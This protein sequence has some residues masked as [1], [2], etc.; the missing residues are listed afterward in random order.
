MKKI[1]LLI[2]IIFGLLSVVR[3][4]VG[5]NSLCENSLPFCTG[6][7]Y[8][9]PA[10]V[11][12]G[13]AQPGPCYSCLTTRPNPAWYFM[14]IGNPGNI[15]IYMYSTPLVDIDFCLWGP[16]TS[17]NACNE[18]T[19]NKVVDCSY[20]PN[21]QEWADIPN[22]LTGQYY[23]LL[24]TNYSNQ[25][26]NINFSQTAGTG[27]TDCSIL[28][29]PCSSNSPLCVGQTL[30][31]TASS[32][33]GA[34]YHWEGP[35][36]WTS[37][38]Q[39]PTILNVNMSHNGLYSLYV[40]ANGQVLDPTTTL[41]HVYN[42]TANAG[43]DQSIPYGANTTLN[44]S[45][46]QGS[47]HY[48]YHW[49]PA[50]LLVNPNIAK[51]TTVNLTATQMFTLTVVDDSAS[52]TDTDVMTVD[53]T[54]GPLGASAAAQP[55]EICPGAT[56]Q[57]HALPSGGAGNYTFQWTGPDGFSSTLQ[58]PMVQPAQTGQ[59]HVAVT[60]GF[61]TANASV[62]V[63][64]HP[65]PLA[66]A[67]TNTGIPHGTYTFLHGN[68]TQGSGNYHYHWTPADKVANPNVKD[69][70][71]V[72]LTQTTVYSLTVDDVTTGCVSNNLANVTVEITGGPLNVNPVATPPM[73][74][75]GETV[76]LHASAGGGN[77]GSYS[78]EWSSVPA[79]FSSTQAN[80]LVSPTVPTTYH[81]KVDDMFN[82]V[83]GDVAVGIRP[84][85]L[86]YLGPADTIVCI[87]D[88]LTLDAGNPGSTYLWSN[89]RDTRTIQVGTSGIGFNTQTLTVEVTSEYGCKSSA[90]IN[91]IFDYSACVGID[92]QDVDGIKV[93][94]NPASDMLFVKLLKEYSATITLMNTHGKVMDVKS[95][96]NM[97]RQAPEVGFDV[98]ELPAGLYFI[99]INGSLI[100]RVC[101]VLI[102]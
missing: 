28:P 96:S 84:D 66:D 30:Q 16:F 48:D 25:P 75:I 8:T 80:P 71:T 88:T 14:K 76:Q 57:L 78:Y 13:T 18:L 67:G 6:T 58:D 2:F 40:T 77:A 93:F 22:G 36:G 56:T 85:P 98:S 12:A 4:Q 60:D 91:I 23:I 52:C 62:T 45:A 15:T 47:A 21:P 68:A 49:E 51:P 63:T 79:G 65:L 1:S 11:N 7:N 54:G 24:I 31:L 5:G 44:G 10:G 92:E 41:V 32:V 33:W 27:T 34:T 69:P 81:V 64:I 94:P 90:S 73:I 37:N 43:S 55:S 101:K 86:I 87:Y 20:S 70:Q 99:H 74:C 42:T 26:C 59:Y 82:L 19:C 35:N 102:R 29:P 3:A 97:Q 61:T 17:Q 89:G 46:S 39:N 95:L 83:E 53:V 9:F 50:N 38:V 72:Y 100:N